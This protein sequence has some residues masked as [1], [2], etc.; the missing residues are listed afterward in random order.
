MRLVALFLVALALASPAAAATPRFGLFD[1]NSDLSHASRNEFGDIKLAKRPGALPGIVVRCA[2]GCRFGYGG[3]GWLA[4]S[5][6]PSLRAGDVR[7]ATASL[8]R[9]GWSLHLRL[10]ARGL[11]RWTA[12]ARAAHG[13][14]R[15]LGVPDVF[16]VVVDGAIV[17]APFANEIRAKG[18]S[19]ELVG[20]HRADARLAAKL[21]G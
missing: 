5:K 14:Q 11:A 6:P 7:G 10:T 4:F 17:A 19:V 12:L 21:L 15:S 20:F 9:V 1:L 13:R 3:A 2:T 16:V 8:G 18:G